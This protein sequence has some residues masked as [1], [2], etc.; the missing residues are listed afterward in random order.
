MRVRRC[1]EFLESTSELI[2]KVVG[3]LLL[4]HLGFAQG[5]LK[6]TSSLP[7]WLPDWAGVE[8]IAAQTDSDILRTQVAELL[9]LVFTD[10]TIF[11][12]SLSEDL[13][14]ALVPPLNILG[15]IYE[16]TASLT[17]LIV[18]CKLVRRSVISYLN[19]GPQTLKVL[20]EALPE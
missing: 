11:L 6:L 13:E 8:E 10:D 9:D 3:L 17:E 14:S 4:I 16:S 5:V 2:L 15:E 7:S 18:A 20:I 1:L 19:D 12:D